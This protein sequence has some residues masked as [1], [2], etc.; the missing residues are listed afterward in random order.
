VVIT[1]TQ[2]AVGNFA[3]FV[4]AREGA[5]AV[6]RQREKSLMRDGA[7][8]LDLTSYCSNNWSHLQSH[9]RVKM[10]MLSANAAADHG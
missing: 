6:R 1:T 2:L 3:M 8:L 4:I 7:E 5:R 9:T 10:A